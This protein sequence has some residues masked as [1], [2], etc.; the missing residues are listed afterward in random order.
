[1]SLRRPAADTAAAAPTRV[2][3]REPEPEPEEEEDFEELRQQLADS[4]EHV[5]QLLAS[6]HQMEDEL[7]AVEASTTIDC[8]AKIRLAMQVMVKI[9]ALTEEVRAFS[10]E[11]LSL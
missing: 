8:D 11:Q 5:K 3:R 6:I 10:A 1:M 7:D 9:R 2:I 4:E